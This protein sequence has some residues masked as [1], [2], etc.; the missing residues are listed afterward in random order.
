M[1]NEWLLKKVIGCIE[2][3]I[4]S[5][6]REVA[7]MVATTHPY[8][9]SAGREAVLDHD[10]AMMYRAS[11]P[12]WL[13]DSCIRALCVRLIEADQQLK[14][15]RNRQLQEVDPGVLAMMKAAVD[16]RSVKFVMIPVNFND[17]HWCA[18]VVRSA[19]KRM[20]NYDSLLPS[21]FSG[22][23]KRHCQKLMELGG[24]DVVTINLPCQKDVYNL[25]VFICCLFIRHIVDNASSFFV[26]PTTTARRLEMFDYI[27]I[28]KMEVLRVH[29]SVTVR[30]RIGEDQLR[31]SERSD[32]KCD[33]EDSTCRTDT[34]SNEPSGKGSSGVV[35]HP[36]TVAGNTMDSQT[37]PVFET[38]TFDH[39]LA[40]ARR[41]SK[42]THPPKKQNRP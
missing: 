5:E 17:A 11:P 25:G 12:V 3:Q 42:L 10:L 4:Y 15:A 32:L 19:E 20:Y 16:I 29:K 13:S 34:I 27:V 22:P 6:V 37:L 31:Y 18:V 23:V 1:M 28:G 2:P 39:V 40:Q 14:C 24:S 36:G 41:C 33:S 26:A 8:I 35:G 30:C 21:V 7:D 38:T 9:K